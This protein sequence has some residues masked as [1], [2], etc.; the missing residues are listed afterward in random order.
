M[1]IM[2]TA[3]ERM[4]I[5]TR[6]DLEDGLAQLTKKEKRFKRALATVSDVP[7]RRR[8][9]GFASLVSILVHQQVSLASAAAIW[10]RVEEGIHP[11]QP[12]TVL[13]LTDEALQGLG[14]SRPKVRYVKALAQA[15]DDGTL[16]LSS[17]AK[18]DEPAARARLTSVV[19]IGDWTADIYLLQSLGHPDIW[20]AKDIGLQ[21][22]AHHLFD[23]P[24][25]PTA[26]ELVELAEPWRPWRSVAARLLWAYYRD[27]NGLPKAR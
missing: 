2:Q 1:G 6:R 19:G 22:A 18:L 26:D 9:Q 27:M 11:F 4:R 5:K 24:S 10:R 23:L 3:N 20:P 8:P 7:L 16:D 15:I 14:L 25:R 12:E 13:A 17:V 21:A